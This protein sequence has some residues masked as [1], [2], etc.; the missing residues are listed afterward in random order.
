MELEGSKRPHGAFGILTKQ[1]KVARE[2]ASKLLTRRQSSGAQTS[3][4]EAPGASPSGNKPPKTLHVDG[5][6]TSQDE[7]SDAV[8][9]LM[10]P[11][12]HMLAQIPQLSR[13]SSA[14]ASSPKPRGVRFG[15]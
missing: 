15:E 6:P 10:P 2:F 9:A 11:P 8:A 5:P 3:E 7:D 13:Q 1:Q 12:A 4:E 14:P